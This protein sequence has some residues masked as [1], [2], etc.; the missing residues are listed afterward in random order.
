[1][2]THPFRPFFKL[3]LT[4]CMLLALM[5][6]VLLNLVPTG[7]ATFPGT[8]GKVA[9]ESYRDS[10]AEIYT[11]NPDGSGQTNLTNNPGN[12][13]SP[14]WSPDGSKIAFYSDRDGNAEIYVMNADGSGQTRLTNNPATDGEPAWSPDGSKIAFNSDRD[15]N[16]DVYEIYVM[17]ADG[18]GQ[19]RLTNNTAVDNRPAWSPDGSKIAFDSDRD[20]NYEIYVMNADGS[21]QTNLTNNP[22]NDATSDWSPDGTK[23]AFGSYRDNSSQSE[24]YVMNADGSGQTNLSNSNSTDEGSQAWSPDGTKIVFH[25]SLAGN[26][27]I[28]VMNADGSGVTR[29]TFNSATDVRPDWQPLLAAT[30]TPTPTPTDTPTTTPTN[31]PPVGG[32]ISGTVRDT[33]GTPIT[34]VSVGVRLEN[35]ADGQVG[36]TVCTDSATGQFTFSN[37]TFNAPVAVS[38]GFAFCGSQI[39]GIEYWQEAT[40]LQSAT[41]ITLTAGAPAV[42]NIDFTLSDALP[43]PELYTFNLDNPILAELAVRQA[44]AHGVDRQRILV[45]AFLLNN[46]FGTLLDSYIPPEYWA[47]A[48]ASALT[49][50]PYDPAL[51]R[52]TLANAGWI[53]SD[54]DGVREK[55]GQRLALTFQT[56]F[57]GPRMTAAEIFR[58]NMAAIGIEITVETLSPGEFF[59]DT[60]PLVTHTFD[61]AEFAWVWG[62]VDDDDQFPPTVWVTGDPQN[63]GNYSNPLA[64]VEYNAAHAA[65]TREDKRPHIVQHQ[66]IL[67]QDLPILPLFA[68][69]SVQPVSVP[70]GNN[71]SVTPAPGLEVTFATVTQAGIITVIETGAN[72]ADLPPNFELLGTVFDVGS[73]VQFTQATVC[74]D[75]DDTGLAPGDEAQLKL[76]HLENGSWVNVTDGGYPDTAANKICGTV[77]SFSPFAILSPTAQPPVLGAISASADPVHVNTAI[78]VT[79]PFTDPNADDNHTAAWS[80]G[81]GTTSAGTVNETSHMATGQY[82]YAA[83]GLYTVTL[84]LTDSSNL[85]VEATFQYVVV[86]NPNGGFVTGGGWITSPAGAYVTDSTLT[87]N[88]KFEFEVKYHKGASV[89]TGN[90]KFKFKAGDLDFKGTSYQWLV[91]T[92]AKAQFAGSGTINGQGDY[93]FLITVVDGKKSGSVPDLIR[94]KIWKKATGQVIYDSQLGAAQ[95]ANPTT[96]L[97][98]GSIVIH[99]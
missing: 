13:G 73:N 88:A 4:V 22:A 14:V 70:E 51:A 71:V 65:T 58:Q 17:N 79:A 33:N 27:E 56:T 10:N 44:I 12:D 64:D 77:S 35:P 89:A 18:T 87:G 25:S 46:V 69:R 76:Y 40:T 67:S 86:Y 19:T 15:G 63:Y 66:V 26:Y 45:E 38:A 39:Y 72:P 31:T 11:M 23:I 16:V 49:L 54:N 60:G 6:G 55:G 42:S 2:N 3:A 30:A 93:G 97:G 90:T 53:D 1:M 59:G 91:V 95:D 94:I 85:S 41:P 5:S 75:Y 29:L 57:S 28:Y 80:W 96:A 98:G 68:R 52:Q 24:I 20:G 50:Y 62:A 84:T 92:G 37:V 7:Y 81:D 61:I 8:N 82:T 32:T 48:P 21:G 83:A 9:F 36:Q 34:G 47:A 99:K 74:F 43:P 78:T